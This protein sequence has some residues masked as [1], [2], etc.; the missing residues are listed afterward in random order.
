MSSRAV[1]AFSDSTLLI[2]TLEKSSQKPE[3]R[4]SGNSDWNAGL[5]SWCAAGRSPGMRAKK[6]L[7]A[8]AGSCAVAGWVSEA[9]VAPSL[10]DG[11]VAPVVGSACS[12]DVAPDEP[13]AA[14]EP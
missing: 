12:E 1:V 13:S 11:S 3:N 14:F 2:C 10:A 9:E 8:S 4:S 5:V 6:S 7:T